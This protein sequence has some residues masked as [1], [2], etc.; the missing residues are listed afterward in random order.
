MRTRRRPGP[1]VVQWTDAANKLRRV[2]DIACMSPEVSGEG[3][4]TITSEPAGAYPVRSVENF[5]FERR[6]FLCQVPK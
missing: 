6:H 2:R 3:D 5:A 4:R 1:T